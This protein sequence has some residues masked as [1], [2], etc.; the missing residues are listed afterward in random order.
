MLLLREI[1]SPYVEEKLILYHTKQ[2][3]HL[4]VT[5]IFYRYLILQN[6]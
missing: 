1:H 6:S 3:S 5:G 4:C 2:D